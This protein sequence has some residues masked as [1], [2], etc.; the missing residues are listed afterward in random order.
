MF[1]VTGLFVRLFITGEMLQGTTRQK[2]WLS[3]SQHQT[4]DTSYEREKSRRENIINYPVSHRAL[5]YKKYCEKC[6]WP[7]GPESGLSC[8]E[9]TFNG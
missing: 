1:V 3:L 2:N 9:T 6:V 5:F 8:L 7:P 4:P